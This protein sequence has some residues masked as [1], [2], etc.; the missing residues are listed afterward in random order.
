MTDTK[1]QEGHHSEVKTV[2][3]RKIVA[4]MKGW[5][6]KSIAR[7]KGKSRGR[8]DGLLSR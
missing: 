6:P 1:K 3:K 5:R 8:D 4:P 2:K 7:V